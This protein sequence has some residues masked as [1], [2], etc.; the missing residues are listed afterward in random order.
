MD[1]V[2]E[3]ESEGFLGLL[4]KLGEGGHPTK[5]GTR[6]G[7]LGDPK[8]TDRRW[9]LPSSRVRGNVMGAESERGRVEGL[10]NLRDGISHS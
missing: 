8:S 7:G 3:S 9:P 4:Q 2:Y 10:K 5:T 6:K 1:A